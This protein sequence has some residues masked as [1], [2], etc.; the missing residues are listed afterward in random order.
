MVTLY[1]HNSD[2]T[3]HTSLIPRPPTWS[4]YEGK[5]IHDLISMQYVR[6][7]HKTTETSYKLILQ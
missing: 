2:S 7:L 1:T 6:I 5:F 3:V 4:G